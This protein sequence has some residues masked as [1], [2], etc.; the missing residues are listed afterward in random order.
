MEPRSRARRMIG[1]RLVTAALI[2]AAVLGSVSAALCETQEV[3][4]AVQPGLSYLPLL[5]AI[6]QKMVEKRAKEMGLGDI[7]VS[8]FNF[9]GA[10]AANQALLSDSVDFSV[11]GMPAALTLWDKTYGT[12]NEVRVTISLG[13]M[14]MKLVTNDPRV[15]TIKDYLGLTDHKI[16]TPSVKVSSQAIFLEMAAEKAF[17]PGQHF[18]LD[19]MTMTVPHPQAVAAILSGGLAIKSHFGSLPFQNRALQS[20][21]AHLV[22]SSY[23]IMGG[24]HIASVM[25]NTKRWKEANPKTFN[26]VHAAILDAYAW[27]NA[28]LDRAAA[29]YKTSS[30]TVEPL[31]EILLIIKD[32]GEIVYDPV[33]KRS[34]MYA[35][36]MHRIGTLSHEAKSWKDLFW[37]NNYQFEGS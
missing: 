17:G 15:K 13:D 18:K 30:K 3:R 9:S 8:T 11:G 34:K 25:Y 24:Q 1:S 16:A 32:K 19:D 29:V 23:D 12:R 28:D 20:G 21:K 31:D 37:E 33:P 10:S 4:F 2:T 6:D 35:D 26:A 14:A 5:V 27:I 36:F 22:V 7:R